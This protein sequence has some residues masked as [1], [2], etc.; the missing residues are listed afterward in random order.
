MKNVNIEQLRIP[1][2]AVVEV[3][4]NRTMELVDNRATA[5]GYLQDYKNLNPGHKFKLVKLTAEK[6]IR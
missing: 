6:F 1:A 5:R 4:S 2:Y 3:T